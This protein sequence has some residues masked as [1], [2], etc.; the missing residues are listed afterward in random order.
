M[1]VILY[2]EIAQKIKERIENGEFKEG[3]KLISE[4]KLAEQYG[5]SRN[6]IRESLKSL[7]Q[8][9][10]LNIIPAKGAFVSKPDTETLANSIK[11]L[12]KGKQEDLMQMM[13][14]REILEL[15]VMES[16]I[17]EAKD[18]H[19][20]YL[21]NLFDKME[22]FVDNSNEYMK[23]DEEFHSYLRDIVKNHILISVVTSL[24]LIV[25]EKLF[26][27][28]V[29]YPERNRIAQEDHYDMIKGIRTR[30]VDLAKD[31]VRRHMDGLRIE[32]MNLKEFS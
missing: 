23:L 15:A 25:R 27:L 8:Q 12:I 22:K 30:N 32:I 7:C 9:G 5:V 18:E 3:E 14:V 28:R 17:M 10:M 13:E 20:K 21:L 24:N 11:L 6:V 16:I 2:I 1:I 4:R 29:L 19:V 26:S 31:A